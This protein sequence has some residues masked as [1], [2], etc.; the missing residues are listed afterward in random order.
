VSEGA[1]GKMRRLTQA[2][3]RA[4]LHLSVEAGWNQTADDWD[5]LLQLAPNGCLAIEVEGE[6][7]ATTTFLSYGQRLAWI[8]MVLTRKKFQGRGFARR[9]LSEALKLAD[10]MKIATVKLDATDQGKPLY[11]KSGFRAEQ[12]VERW[13][14]TGNGCEVR[15]SNVAPKEWYEAD[16][17]AFG[18]NRSPLLEELAERNPPW[19]AAKSF[20]LGRA[21]IN[22]AYMGP[23]VSDD[24]QSA[25][26]LIERFVQS[27]RAAIAWDFLPQN[28]EAVAIA[29]ELNF[30]PQRHLTRMVRGKDLRAKE[31][32]IYAL[33]GFEFG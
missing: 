14:R 8:G 5:M 3:I 27:T 24:S 32:S 1:Q 17:E 7:A 29:K 28:H 33:A 11:E 18:A 31:T 6:V 25:R 16:Q 23:C 30:A 10:E 19:F 26:I 13:L 4:A 2:D 21:G 15:S 20:L 12:P 22:T 9:L